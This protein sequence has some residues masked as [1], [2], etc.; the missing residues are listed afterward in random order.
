MFGGRGTY[1]YLSTGRSGARAG[2]GTEELS[3][4]G[5]RALYRLQ[6]PCVLSGPR[7]HR[8][9]LICVQGHGLSIIE[10][11]FFAKLPRMPASVRAGL[12]WGL[13]PNK[14]FLVACYYY[15]SVVIMTQK[16]IFKNIFYHL[17]IFSCV[18]AL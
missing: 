7:H 6:H 8:E 17:D 14:T 5:S 13:Q 10:D 3:G 15:F 4:V 9:E 1:L 18:L 2:A 16:T 11:I 12:G